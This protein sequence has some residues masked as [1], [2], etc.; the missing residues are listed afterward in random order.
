[1]GAPET[2]CGGVVVSRRIDKVALPPMP[3]DEG[4]ASANDSAGMLYR[5]GGIGSGLLPVVAR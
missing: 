1:M 2:L 5:A 3:M 4:S